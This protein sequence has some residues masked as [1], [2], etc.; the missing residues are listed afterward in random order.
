LCHILFLIHDDNLFF[1]IGVFRPLTYKVIVEMVEST[2]ASLVSVLSDIF[3][4]CVQS[5]LFSC[6]EYTAAVVSSSEP[7]FE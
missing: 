2:S 7:S 6:G 3:L 4:G 1:L 5:T